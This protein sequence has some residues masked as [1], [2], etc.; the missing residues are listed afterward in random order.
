MIISMGFLIALAISYFYGI[1][2]FII[3]AFAFFVWVGILRQAAN[4][5]R[6]RQ[7]IL[8]SD[9]KQ[10]P[11][12]KITLTSKKIIGVF[13]GIDIPETV[14]DSKNKTYSFVGISDA[15]VGNVKLK[16]GEILLS[17]GLIY[18]EQGETK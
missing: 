11:I 4:G 7:G 10:E 8:T 16:R 1:V 2:G 5:V 14:I 3:T 15:K 6:A 13:N 12:N 17:S 9:I 18:M